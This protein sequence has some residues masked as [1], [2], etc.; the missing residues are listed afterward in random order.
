MKHPRK[1]KTIILNMFVA[2]LAVVDSQT[3]ILR[4][5]LT[6]EQFIFAL[7]AL[8]AINVGLRAITREALSLK[9]EKPGA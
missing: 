8:A 6:P 9:K 5:I 1:S 7:A 4:E 3:S 2:A